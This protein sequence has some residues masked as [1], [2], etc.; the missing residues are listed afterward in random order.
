MLPREKKEFFVSEVLPALA[1]AGDV[2]IDP[3]LAAKFCREDLRTEVYFERGAGRGVGARVEF[4][5]GLTVINPFAVR[6]QAPKESTGEE[7]ILVRAAEREEQVLGILEQADFSVS[8]GRIHL[9]DDE[10]VF[11]LATVYLPQ[12]QKVAEIYYS[13]DFRFRLRSSVSFSGRVRLNESL[14]LLEVSFQYGDIDESELV[15]IFQALRRKKKYFRL[16]DGSFLPLNQPELEDVA[17]LLDEL[18]LPVEDLRRKAIRLPKYRA[19]YI[20]NFLRCSGLQG[21]ARNGAFKQLV[22]SIL[23]PQDSEFVVP[24]HLERVMRDYQKTG[25]KWLKTLASYGLGGI[26][27]DDMGLG[28]TLQVLSFLLSE[29]ESIGKPALVVVPTSLVYNWL[30]EAKKFVPTLKVLVIEG[31]PSERQAQLQDIGDWDLIV[32]SYPVLR[33]D[34]EYYDNLE[35]SYC[36]LDEAQHIKNPQTVN[37]KSVRRIQA[38]GYFAL[39]GTPIENS[40]SELWSVFNFILPGYLYSHAE[41]TKKF[42]VSPAQEE[43][44][45]PL[46]EL[47]RQVAPFILRRLKKNVLVELPDKIETRLVVQMTEDQ[48]KIYLAFLLEAKQSIVRDIASSGFESSRLKIL[49]AL[50][51]LRQICCH[52][53]LFLEDYSGESGKML[54]FQEILAGALGSGHR[55]LVFSQ[56]TSMLDIIQRHL[57]AEGIGHFYLQGSTKASDRSPMVKS[58]NAGEGEVFLISLKAGGTGLNLTGAD[59]VIHFDP[60]WNPAVEDQATDRAYRIGQEKAVQVLKLVTQGTIEEKVC[61]LQEKKKELIEQVIQPGETFVSKLTEAELRGLFEIS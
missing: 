18:K 16:R 55:L 21:V 7:L 33:R 6:G 30:E 60:W 9:E 23:E 54:L 48:K 35:F 15:D 10:K 27:A 29:R 3:E 42:D 51:R 39:T 25:F 47:S 14:D 13:D 40:L 37:A 50:T 44:A 59:M 38:G 1:K 57:L 56:F 36:F 45:G 58:F 32:T 34:I 49:A 12:L 19:L 31:A 20:D 26:L 61:T 4:H 46:R 28:K 8:Q 43:G 53:G 11:T 2:S 17:E 41:F 22:Q 52:P 24:A 5:Y